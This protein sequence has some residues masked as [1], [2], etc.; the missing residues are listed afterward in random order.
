[1]VGEIIGYL[2]Y[3]LSSLL[4]LITPRPK[5]NMSVSEARYRYARITG[6]GVQLK[7]LWIPPHKGLR[8]HN[9]RNALV[10]HA[11]DREAVEHSDGLLNRSF[12]TVITVGKN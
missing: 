2:P 12:K 10:K 3:F 9:K 8:E 4:A 1:M 11:L 5:C 7:L 6:K